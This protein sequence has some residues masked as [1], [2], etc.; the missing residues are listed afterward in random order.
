MKRCSCFLFI[1]LQVGCVGYDYFPDM[2]YSPAVD[3]Q[4][5]DFI[6]KRQGAMLP[7]ENTIPYGSSVYTM[8]EYL[9]NY[10][11]IAS[12]LKSPFNHISN[13]VLRRG[14]K[15]YAI[16]CAPCHGISGKGDGPIKKKWVGVRPLVQVP[17]RE[18]PPV[19]WPAKRIY[20]V[21]QVGIR[22]MQSYSTHILEKDKWAIAH[23][24]KYLQKK[25]A[26]IW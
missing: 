12:E 26:V 20:H 3:S 7:P 24:V 18:V 22:S 11:Q 25:S 9:Q 5:Y 23:Y 17:N 2:H 10:D 15:Q 6:G 1:F 19:T 8:K 4:E 16:Y 21:I 14:K 13:I